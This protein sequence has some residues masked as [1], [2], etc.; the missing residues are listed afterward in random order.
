MWHTTGGVKGGGAGGGAGANAGQGGG[1]S[2]LGRGEEALFL[3]LH[4]L[5]QHVGK[6]R[7]LAALEREL[8]VAVNES[9]V[10]LNAS[11]LHV[12]RRSMLSFVAGL[13]PVKA[14]DLVS[15]VKKLKHSQV[16]ARVELKDKQLL[17]AKVFQNAAGF[18]RIRD[19]PLVN[20]NPVDDTRIHPECYL[21]ADRDGEK[22]VCLF[23]EMI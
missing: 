22:L 16:S 2:A 21:T 6:A 17:G 20:L 3:P 13:G 9:G 14:H 7:L 5:H 19:Y 4:P 11:A 15:K 18:L 23:V 10:S 12:H 8:L 1:G